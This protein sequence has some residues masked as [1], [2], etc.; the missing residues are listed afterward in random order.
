MADAVTLR[1][2][3]KRFGDTVALDDVDLAVGDQEFFSLLGPSGCGN[4]TLLRLVGGLETPTSG[5]IEVVGED[6]ARRPPDRRP[7]NTVFQNYA[8][9]PHLNVAANVGFGLRMLGVGKAEARRRVA[10]A[11]DMVRLGHLGDRR[12]TQLSGGQQQRVA[13]ARALVN[14]PRVLLL[15]EPL[16]ALDLQLRR[17]MQ[18]ELKALQR[19]LGIAF[20]FVTHDQDEAF[21][22][23]DRVAVMRDGRLLQVDTPAGIYERPANRFVARFVGQTNLLEATVVDTATICLANGVRL[24]VTSGLPAGTPVSALLRPESA[25]LRCGDATNGQDASVH[26]TVDAVTY[27]G[28]SVLYRVRMDWMHLDVRVANT[29]RHV[30]LDVGDDVTATWPSDAVALVPA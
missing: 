17:E 8:L 11:L 7:V 21:A 6:M 3:T 23:S 20:V 19:D 10:E 26:G 13:L 5:V 27:L 15:D 22:M 9:F 30:R 12:T 28:N 18:Q 1:G 16:A 25:R 29:P 24:A 14:R 2:V 4:S